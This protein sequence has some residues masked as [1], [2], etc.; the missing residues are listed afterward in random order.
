MCIVVGVELYMGGIKDGLYV[1]LDIDDMVKISC[2]LCVQLIKVSCVEVVEVVQVFI[3]QIGLFKFDEVLVVFFKLIKELVMGVYVVFVNG[4]GLEKFCD[5]IDW[6][7][8]SLCKC[9]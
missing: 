8:V 9:L 6:M 7:V 4:D 5:E 3:D 2:E 1:K